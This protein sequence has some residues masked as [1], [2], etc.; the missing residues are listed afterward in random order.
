MKIT[1]KSALLLFAIIL[2]FSSCKDKIVEENF[3][4][5]KNGNKQVVRIYKISKGE[6]TLI[7]EKQYYETGELKIEGTYD[8]NKR[9]GVWKSYYKNGNL[10]SKGTYIQG[11]ENGEKV[12]NYENGDLYY[13]GEVLNDK[14]VGKW[15]FIGIDG[16][17]SFINY[18][19]K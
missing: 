8:N 2:L 15:K 19:E 5:F 7:G 3:S 4:T 12:V 10:W 1:I 18:D 16:K 17:E 9:H 14:R 6:K 13:K 11:I